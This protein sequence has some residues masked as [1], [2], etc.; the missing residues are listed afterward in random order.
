LPWFRG[1]GILESAVPETH[2][3][4]HTCR[5]AI[6]P[7]SVAEFSI[8]SQMEVVGVDCCRSGVSDQMICAWRKQ[9]VIDTGVESGLGSVEAVELRVAKRRIKVVETELA[10]IRRANEL[11]KEQVPSP[12]RTVR[13]R[14]GDC[15]RG[16]TSPDRM[17]GVGCI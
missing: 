9:E 6:H 8:W 1:V 15:L 13:S 17:P 2:I 4:G 16:L 12:R 5:S 10:V 11:L 3:E 7:S 14:L